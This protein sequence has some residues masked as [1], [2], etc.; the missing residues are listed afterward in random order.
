MENRIETLR[1]YINTI[2][3]EIKDQD[4]LR[5]A[6]IHLYGVSNICALIAL[7]RNQNVELATMAGML[8]DFYT[9]K[10][11]DSENHGQKGAILAKETLDFLKI[12]TSDET[13]LIC[14]AISVHSDKKSKHS[15]FTEILVDA[16]TLQPYLYNINFPPINEFRFKRT[17]KLLEE[18]GIRHNFIVKII[19][20]KVHQFGSLQKY[21][22]ADIFPLYKGKWIYCKHKD[23]STWENPGGHIENSEK[24]LDTAKRELY[25]ETGSINFDIEPLCDYW[26]SGEL[27]GKSITGN[28]QVY[29]ANVHSISKLPEESEME[30]I[31][32][33]DLPPKKLTYPEYSNIIFPLALE[34]IKNN[35]NVL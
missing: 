4:I 18:F 2:I 32:F 28:G 23:R 5:D 9:Y 25:E 30:K 20:C 27:N 3:S 17:R 33:F 11:L 21:D 10:M 14:N 13:E 24:P 6:Y 29:F 26:I 34:K 22:Y 19:E 16:D 31:D 35:K 8:H 12:T 15:D 1:E 7:K